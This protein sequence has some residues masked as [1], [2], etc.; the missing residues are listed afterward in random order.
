M[1][2]F[3]RKLAALVGFLPFC[4]LAAPV[5]L[6][7]DWRY[8]RTSKAAKQAQ[9]AALTSNWALQPFKWAHA[10]LFCSSGRPQRW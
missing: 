3:T 1:K 2:N 5:V 6:Y 4:F 10:T 9:Q 8:G 7:T